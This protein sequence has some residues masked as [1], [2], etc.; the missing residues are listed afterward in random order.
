MKCQGWLDSLDCG[1]SKINYK[2]TQCFLL[3]W[4]QHCLRSLLCHLIQD[5]LKLHLLLMS[6]P[7]C[8]R[9]SARLPVPKRPTGPLAP[10][11][12]LMALRSALRSQH[13]QPVIPRLLSRTR[14][15]AQ[16]HCHLYPF[17][18]LTS[19]TFF[20][21]CFGTGARLGLSRSHRSALTSWESFNE[22]AL[23]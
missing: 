2:T 11:A 1:H 13:N 8:R 19:F 12:V 10:N 4:F 16:R 14:T 9:F 5:F 17:E 7:W 20:V 6:G 22:R 15:S 23:F 18:A 3:I 21:F